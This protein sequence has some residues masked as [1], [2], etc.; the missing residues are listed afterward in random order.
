MPRRPKTPATPPAPPPM[1]EYF[2]LYSRERHGGQ[3]ISLHHTRED[4]ETALDSFADSI[5]PDWQN[6]APDPEDLAEHRNAVI[7]DEGADWYIDHVRIADLP[8]R[9][10]RRRAQAPTPQLAAALGAAAA[11]PPLN[12][13]QRANFAALQRAQ[14]A[15]HLALV[16]CRVRA[17]GEP[18]AVL[19]AVVFDGQDYQITPLALQFPESAGNPYEYL[20]DP[21][22]DNGEPQQ[23]AA[24]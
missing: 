16:S 1:R 3:A 8:A 23:P 10:T 13:A 21:T 22:D 19:A 14:K 24:K 11:P 15:G 20:A 6:D 18:V 17:T 5:R 4:A 7:D 9:P 2:A 12:D